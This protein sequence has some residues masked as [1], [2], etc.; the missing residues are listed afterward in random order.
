MF[1]KTSLWRAP[2]AITP[3]VCT[4]G[5][6]ANE[7]FSRASGARVLQSQREPTPW[8][9]QTVGLDQIYAYPKRGGY[10]IVALASINTDGPGCYDVTLS[11]Y[12]F[13]VCVSRETA[14]RIV[15]AFNEKALGQH[16]LVQRDVLAA[17][18]LPAGDWPAWDGPGRI[19]RSAMTLG[20]QARSC[21][22]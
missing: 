1:F 20:V 4:V 7:A 14:E 22:Q 17:A 12:D 21:T 18:G 5:K 6:A 19:K 8:D 9:G 2:S 10:G 15:T 11:T 3:L 16:S 13:G